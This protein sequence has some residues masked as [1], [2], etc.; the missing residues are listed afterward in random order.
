MDLGQDSRVFIFRTFP[1]K[2]MIYVRI[3]FRIS[4]STVI[5]L[6]YASSQFN[7][8]YLVILNLRNVYSFSQYKPS[9]GTVNDPKD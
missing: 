9:Q 3:H 4:A 7:V 2:T 6:H 1:N 8:T 5:L